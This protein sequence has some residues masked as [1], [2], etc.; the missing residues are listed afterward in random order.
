MERFTL[1]AFFIIL[2]GVIHSPGAVAEQ[3]R[4]Y[5][6]IGHWG[7]VQLVEHSPGLA[8]LVTAGE[9]GSIRVWSTGVPRLLR[10][11]TISP[12]PLSHLTLH[13]SRPHAAVIERSGSS[14]PVLSVWDWDTGTRVFRSE[15]PSA[16]LSIAYSPNGTFLV[17]TTESIDSVVKVS[18]E[19]G[20]V[21]EHGVTRTG[22]VSYFTV[23]GS[24]TTLMAYTPGNGRFT[25]YNITDGRVLQSVQSEPQLEKLAILPNR[26]L[27]VGV[28]GSDVVVVDILRGGIIDRVEIRNVRSLSVNDVNSDIGVLHSH[29]GRYYYRTWYIDRNRLGEREQLMRELNRPPIGLRFFDGKSLVASQDGTLSYFF[30]QSRYPRILSSNRRLAVRGIAYSAGQLYLQSDETFLQFSGLSSA[31][32][33]S[34]GLSLRNLAESSLQLPSEGSYAVHGAVLGNLWF[35]RTDVPQPHLYQLQAGQSDTV[36][37]SAYQFDSD[38]VGHHVAKDR[39][40]VE[41]L[42]GQVQLWNPR[43]AQVE[44]THSAPQISAYA[45]HPV[46]GLSIGT[47]SAAGSGRTLVHINPGTGETIALS[48]PAFITTDVVFSDHTGSLYALGI[49]HSS[50]GLLYT[51]LDRWSGAGFLTQENL[52]RT[53]GADWNARL[54]SVPGSDKVWALPSTGRIQVWDAGGQLSVDAEG[55]FYVD[56]G[57]YGDLVYAVHRS[58]AVSF[59]S[60]TKTQKLLTLYLF[61]DRE[62]VAIT[63][64]QQFLL[65]AGAVPEDYL[66]LVSEQQPSDS[67]APVSLSRFRLPLPIGD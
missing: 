2:F 49:E 38:I 6:A 8:R 52:Y 7:E 1:L 54:A 44:Y 56:L 65:S 57:V 53:P 30:A 15:L 10:A 4:L 31:S 9:D 33:T 47:N 60:A 5:P 13:P 39:I 32:T 58:G 27:A 35:R 63:P 43:T 50:S 16:P 28:Q 36:T 59:Y 12:H 18:P 19:N 55:E 29:N 14:R 66:I 23:S 34:L 51:R 21:I 11:H 24:E 40:L 64:E 25:Y 62:W 48:T 42:A 3:D 61:R 20:S 22:I 17:Y 37:P 67:L 46:H 45:Y 41:T 26:R